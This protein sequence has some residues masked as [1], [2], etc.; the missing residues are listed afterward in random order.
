M[1][2]FLPRNT[3]FFDYFDRDTDILVR[4]AEVFAEF[5]E[6]SGDPKE[7]SRRMKELEHEA[8]KVTHEAMEL[9]HRS[10]ITPLERGDLRR[11]TLAL[12]EFVDYLDDATRRICLYEVGPILPEA[13]AMG[14]IAV[15][16]AK[17]VKAAVQDLRN[18]RSKNNRVREHCIE[19]QRLENVGDH[20][21]HIALASIFKMG[22][23]P[24]AVMKWKEIIDLIELA[25]DAAEEVA[26]VIEGT[27]L[28]NA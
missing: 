11:L 14:K 18:L 6:R 10:F 8:D 3:K 21:H 1:F 22:M 24:V 4:A 9:L 19:I 17:A 23:D 26:H 20:L 25:M 28:E 12:D 2:N 27:V 5:L 15:D 7:Y 13:C 16:L